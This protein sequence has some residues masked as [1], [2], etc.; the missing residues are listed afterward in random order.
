MRWAGRVR[1]LRV[2][3]WVGAVGGPGWL[4]VGG[5]AAGRWEVIAVQG[6]RVQCD[7]VLGRVGLGG[8][9]GRGRMGVVRCGWVGR[10]LGGWV[11]PRL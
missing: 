5:D 7:R 1:W 3:G 4:A 2:G 9:G 8:W 6:G 10:C 11:G